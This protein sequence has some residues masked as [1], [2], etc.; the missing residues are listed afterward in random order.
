LLFQSFQ[1]VQLFRQSCQFISGQSTGPGTAGTHSL[2]Q[3]GTSAGS[4]ATG[5]GLLQQL[6]NL[7]ST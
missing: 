2:T 5:S 6:L 3:P 7:F 4:H 1:F